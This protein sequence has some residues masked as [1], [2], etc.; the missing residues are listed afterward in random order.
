[1]YVLNAFLYIKLGKTV[2]RMR[3]DNMIACNIKRNDF[4][5]SNLVPYFCKN[6]DSHQI[7]V[8]LT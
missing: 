3:Y 6:L 7:K 1:M 4:Q 8:K 5:I 2:K